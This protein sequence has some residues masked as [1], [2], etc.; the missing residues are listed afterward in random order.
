VLQKTM[1]MYDDMTKNHHALS[2]TFFI[3]KS[4]EI[5]INVFIMCS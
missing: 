2:L 1:M 4:S 3:T 5:N